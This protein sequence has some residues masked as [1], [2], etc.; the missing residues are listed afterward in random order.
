MKNLI[1]F[2]C[3]CVSEL[4]MS[5]SMTKIKLKNNDMVMNEIV[6]M[7][8]VANIGVTPASKICGINCLNTLNNQNEIMFLPFY[9][10]SD[11]TTALFL[12]HKVGNLYIRKVVYTGHDDVFF[13]GSYNNAGSG[14]LMVFGIFSL[15]LKSIKLLKVVSLSN[16]PN[17]ILNPVDVLY[18]NNIFYI[19]GESP[20]SYLTEFNSKIILIK[21]DGADIL[22]SKIYNSVAPINS[23]VPSS[24]N[25]APN[26]NLIVSGTIKRSGDVDPK[27][28]LAQFDT[29]G[30]P[31]LMKSVDLLFPDLK[32]S[33]R[34]G[35][36]YVKSK[37]TNIH[38]FSQAIL[39]L[40]EPGTVLVT[41]FD[42]DLNL[43]TWRNYTAPIR[44]ES[45]NIDGNFFLFGGQAPIES[46]Y[47]GYALMKVNSA[48]AIVEQ[49][50]NYKREL[51]N[52][53]I[54]TSSA[55]TY[56]RATDAIWTIVKPNGSIGNY[57]VLLENPSALDHRCAE[58]FTST[59]AKDTMRL[60]EIPVNVKSLQFQLSDIDGNVRE[61]ELEIEEVCNTTGT[62]G[63]SDNRIE[64]FP[65]PS[66]GSYSVNSDKTIKS[67]RIINS[68]GQ[69]LSHTVI[70]G[71]H[72]QSKMDLSAGIYFA[73]F[74]LSDNSIIIE[75]LLI[76]D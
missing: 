19:L 60:A 3:C 44:V 76:N 73:Q 30:N 28:M 2:L 71:K 61:S 72:Y 25:L 49:F 18:E 42:N 46:G 63:L 54:A 13:L 40:S 22:W 36:T 59:V 33:N 17:F 75:R 10:E 52:S 6:G 31:V 58:N 47:E 57:L 45:A 53:S 39:G 56:D 27:M 15:K 29:D 35:W 64:I 4:L 9:N 69:Q 11:I 38:L 20:I 8:S 7:S 62:S 67:L 1:V 65:N 41:M 55:S 34:F 68:Y 48:N 37:G 51:K 16:D 26:G 5:Q 32:H 14:N 70:N 43:R 23:E 24:I 66:N 74:L 21:F 50:K 12:Y